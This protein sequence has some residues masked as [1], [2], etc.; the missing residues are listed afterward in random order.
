MSRGAGSTGVVHRIDIDA[1]AGFE[2]LD[3]LSPRNEIAERWQF[4]E[5]VEAETFEEH[6]RGSEEHRLAGTR[7]PGELT[8]VA[9]LLQR[10]HDAIDVD[11]SDRSDLG[12]GD[13]LLVGNDRQRLERSRRQPRGLSTQDEPFDIGSKIGMALES[14][15]AGDL[16]ELETPHG[17]G[18]LGRQLLTQFLAEFGGDLEQ[19]CQQTR[20]GRFVGD[21]DH[22]LDGPASL[23]PDP[24]AGLG[25][26]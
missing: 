7:V 4:V 22:R 8:D 14:P 1:E 25:L 2:C 21:H 18:I 20:V 6:R 16:D 24:L 17:F 11:P 9:T 10:P 23:F 26:G 15:A 3:H 12:P 13:R 5:R 19:L